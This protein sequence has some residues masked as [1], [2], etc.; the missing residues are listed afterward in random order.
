MTDVDRPVSPTLP[1]SMDPNAV[2]I[3]EE[4]KSDLD[5][6]EAAENKAKEDADKADAEA[7]VEPVVTPA[8]ATTEEDGEVAEVK[9]EASKSPA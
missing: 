6:A 7:P 4:I 5:I 2:P 8:P 9:P 3:V 1:E